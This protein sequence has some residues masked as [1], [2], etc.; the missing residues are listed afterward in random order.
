[1]DGAFR[2][3]GFAKGG[4]GAISESI[5]SAAR[6]L[7]AEIKLET[8]VRRIITTGGRAVGVALENGDEY[9]ASA[10]VTSLDPKRTFL[11]LLEPNELPS[12]F[13][14][15]IRRYKIRGSSG[16]VNLALSG[17]PNFTCLPGIGPLHRGA[18][19]ISPS[20]EYV[21]TAYDDAK[22]GNFSR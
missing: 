17:L 6:A 13:V 18:V 11:K 22:H 3:W 2:A 19:S 7:G 14:E 12:D 20:M 9:R 1:I 4:T 10:V 16:K 15:D 21:E 8:P 5:A